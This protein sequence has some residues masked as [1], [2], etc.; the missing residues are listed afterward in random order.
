[1]SVWWPMLV[2]MCLLSVFM[3]QHSVMS[4]EFAKRLFSRLRIEYTNRSVY[5]VASSLCLHLLL[6]NWR[7]VPPVALW[8][9]DTLTSNF[10]WYMFTGCHVL[11]WSIIYSGCL[12]VDI[13]E[14]AGLKQIY[15]K[16]S[17]LPDPMEIKSR[18]LSR[19]YSHMRHPSFTGFLIILWI[20]PFMTIDR[21]L[22]ATVLTA[23]MALMWNIDEEDNNY[24][25]MLF[26]RKK[27][28]LS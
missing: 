23:Y 20:H 21:T 15:Y 12:M 3:I 8:K 14:L 6:S 25:T 2:D 22:L 5:N 7:S 27:L 9:V 16:I 18:E 19:Y 1:M 13:S 4:T 10:S 24:H 28:E 17:C 11:A 26:R